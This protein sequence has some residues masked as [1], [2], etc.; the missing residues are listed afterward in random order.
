[1][2]NRLKFILASAVLLSVVSCDS[3][4][5]VEPRN[6]LSSSTALSDAKSYEALMVS[7]YD[8]IQAFTYWGRDMVLMGEALSDNAFVVTSQASG[9]YTGQNKN[10]RGSHF[11]IWGTA[12]GAINDCN[13]IIATIDKITDPNQAALRDK[14]KGEALFLR[15]LL[16]FDL[17][18]V[19]SYEPTKVP[20][21]GTG[22]NW[23]KGVLLR[24]TPVAE[25]TD[26][27][28]QSRA[29]VTD[30]YTAIEQSLKSAIEL[31]PKETARSG[32]YRG[33][34]A[35]AYALLGK[36]YLYWERWD[37]AI[38]NFDLALANT[39]ATQIAANGYGS[40][41]KGQPNTESLFEINYIQSVEVA[42]VTGINDSPFTYTQPTGKN[43]LGLSTYGG[44]TPS[45]E[46]L[47]LFE[48]ADD[49]SKMFFTSNSSTTNTV[50][51]WANKY[52][53][54]FGNYTDNIPVIR[55]SDV[56]LMKA[57]ALAEKGFYTDAQTLII[58]LRT[59]R[60]ASTASVPSDAAIIDYILDERRREL[61][62][63]GSRWF[64]LKRK[65]R[66][67]KKAAA[68]AVGEIAYED[69]RLLAPIPAAEVILNPN[70]LPQNPNY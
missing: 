26:A 33:N 38:A 65:G 16:Y 29:T 10:N 24:L 56:V 70:G 31:L 36:L 44:M 17:A 23:N 50:Y 27:A 20:A 14:V 18:R 68:T 52:S 55:Y 43:A 6:S 5:E 28:L 34:K 30:V 3:L 11:G 63:E 69:Y 4:V 1:M 19:Y 7:A 59:K 21:S 9:R 15:G 60:N 12:Y 62:F 37:D 53:S 45:A 41:F 64:D 54:A 8:R 66:A 22:A 39:T 48:P 67:I 2:R 49:R 57:E 32:V 47:A 46:L 42:G 61:F 58:D 35:A 40:A 13:T 51:T 25:A